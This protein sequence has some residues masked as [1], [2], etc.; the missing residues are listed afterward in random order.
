MDY[1]M[2]HAPS[3]AAGEKRD[4]AVRAVSIAIGVDYQFALGALAAHGRKS[5]DGTPMMITHRTLQG[6]GWTVANIP[7][8][9]LKGKTVRTIARELPSDGVFLVR[10]RSHILCVKHGKA[11]DWTKGRLFKVEEVL[12]IDLK[13]CEVCGVVGNT[14]PIEIPPDSF[15]DLPQRMRAYLYRCSFT[16]LSEYY[17]NLEVKYMC[18][19]CNDEFRRKVTS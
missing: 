13:R 16:Q 15:S 2:T 12:R 1:D 4:C 6:L 17:D 10:T 14:R 8:E 18:P 5:R 7:L 9:T 3:S 11:E 19:C